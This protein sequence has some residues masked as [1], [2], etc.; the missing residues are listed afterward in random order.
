MSRGY[1]ACFVVSHILQQGILG[2][3]GSLWSLLIPI[4]V[5]LVLLVI[6]VYWE[7]LAFSEDRH[8][9]RPPLWK[10]LTRPSGLIILSALG[11]TIYTRSVS[12]L[13]WMI[14]IFAM[15]L[16][17]WE[18]QAGEDDD[19]DLKEADIDRARDEVLRAESR[20]KDKRSDNDE[21]DFD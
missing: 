17:H 20:R 11:L 13:T 16:R 21:D 6:C 14:V 8:G 18:S 2:L 15:V 19:N 7:S 3:P 1:S 5:F 9:K 12:R 10:S 4:M